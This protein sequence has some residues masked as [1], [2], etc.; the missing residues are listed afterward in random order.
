ME[1]I[2]AKIAYLQ[3]LMDGLDLDKDSKEAK[4]F[5]FKIMIGYGFWYFL[6]RKSWKRRLTR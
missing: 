4:I 1:N 5:S 6:R 3:G 2:T